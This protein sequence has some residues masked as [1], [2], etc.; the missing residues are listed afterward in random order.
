M[1]STGLTVERSALASA[2]FSVRAMTS[3]LYF[4]FCCDTHA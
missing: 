4:V 1:G 3:L 2:A